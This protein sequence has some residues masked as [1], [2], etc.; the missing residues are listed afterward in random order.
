MNSLKAVF[1]GEASSMFDRTLC[2]GLVVAAIL[3]PPLA[4]ADGRD[5]K[6]DYGISY[7]TSEHDFDTNATSGTGTARSR[8]GG[9]WVGYHFT[10]NF[11]AQLNYWWLAAGYGLAP[12]TVAQSGGGYAQYNDAWRDVYGWSVS[13]TA[14]WPVNEWLRLTAR[15]GMFFWNSETTASVFLLQ[16]RTLSSASGQ[17]PT[18]GAGFL[19][20]DP[21][22]LRIDYDAFERV[23]QSRI[24]TLTGGVFCR[25]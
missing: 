7:G 18:Y 3:F 2:A 10:P 16:T 21:C 19:V 5:A 20:G 24:Q 25:F 13:G 23:D 22:G 9:I 12:V 8:T 15:A 17:S 4:Q 1:S 14:T 11:G 6:F